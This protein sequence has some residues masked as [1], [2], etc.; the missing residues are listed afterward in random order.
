MSPD[1]SV[2]DTNVLVYAHLTASPQHADSLALVDRAKDPAAG[3]CVFPQMVTE[4]FAIVTNPKRVTTPMDCPTALTAVDKLLA[5]P[6]LAVLPVPADLVSR[7]MA[8]LR[9]A[10]VTGP[11]VFDYQIA[12]AMLQAGIST[13]YTYNTTDFA[14][15]PGIVVKEPPPTAPPVPPATTSAAS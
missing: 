14:G 11:K 5:Y 2:V 7:V 1:R 13:P 6:G 3:L 4:F 9:A 12:A 10:P 8:L 15:I